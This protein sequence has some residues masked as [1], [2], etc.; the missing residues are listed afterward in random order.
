M[1]GPVY[2]H[3][4]KYLISEIEAGILKGRLKERLSPDPHAE[5]G[6]YFIRSLYFDDFF[7]SAYTDKQAGTER[8]RKFRI[9]TYNYSDDFISLECKDKEGSYIYKRNA[10]I[11]VPE[12]DSILNGD[13]SFLAER[14]EPVLKE[15][16]ISSVSEG[17]RPTVLVDYDRTPFILNAGTVRVT[18]DEH[19]RSAFSGRDIFDPGIP[20]YETLPEGM[21]IMEVKYTEFFPD[22][23]RELLETMAPVQTAASKYVMCSDKMRDIRGLTRTV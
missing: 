10:V 18:F 12:L 8:R 13:Y 15:F 23:V 21:L 14:E 3:E 2:R 9:R 7:D 11:S 19:I 4:L 17:L 1:N 16:Y 6:R 5:N 20:V 22:T